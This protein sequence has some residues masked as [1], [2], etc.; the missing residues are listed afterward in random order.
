MT[1]EGVSFCKYHKCIV[2]D[3]NESICPA[4]NIITYMKTSGNIT[5]VIKYYGC[6]RGAPQRRIVNYLLPKS[7]RFVTVQSYKQI[8]PPTFN[9]ID[10]ISKVTLHRRVVDNTLYS[11]VYSAVTV[12]GTWLFSRYLIP[13]PYRF[14]APTRSSLDL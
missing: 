3:C 8:T 10:I 6:R 13:I 1:D 5:G 12:L 9:P 14:I 11:K 2:E 4:L 7:N